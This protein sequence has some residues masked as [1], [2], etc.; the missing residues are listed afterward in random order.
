MRSQGF[1]V[2]QRV[3][4]NG[5]TP[6]LASSSRVPQ[7][8]Q[9]GTFH[10]YDHLQ[11]SPQRQISHE[12][13][14]PGVATAYSSFG[15]QPPP[16][17]PGARNGV[18]APSRPMPGYFNDP[19]FADYFGASQSSGQSFSRGPVPIVMNDG[20]GGRNGDRQVEGYHRR[21]EQGSLRTYPEFQRLAFCRYSLLRNL[22]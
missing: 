8:S 7:H 5:R 6:T 10:P 13:V 17:M 12:P 9:S 22:H 20:F 16:P 18:D 4:D 21:G 14:V 3:Y 19:G 15:V 1:N 11:P 2:G